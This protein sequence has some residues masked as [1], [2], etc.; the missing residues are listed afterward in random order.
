MT[1]LYYYLFINKGILKSMRENILYS[2]SIWK[3]VANIIYGSISFIA[4]PFSYSWFL[5][6]LNNLI[7]RLLVGSGMIE[8]KVILFM[9][10]CFLI[11]FIIDIVGMLIIAVFGTVTFVFMIMSRYLDEL[12]DQEKRIEHRVRLKNKHKSLNK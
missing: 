4:I 8:N 2:K 6:Y 11:I 9:L 12:F 3:V 7:V 5:I 10:V 1:V